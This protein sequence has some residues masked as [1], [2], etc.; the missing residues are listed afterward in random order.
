[1]REVRLFLSHKHLVAMIELLTDLI[2]VF[3]CLREEEDLRRGERWE[4]S[5]SVERPAHTGH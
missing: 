3:L 4:N 2:S 1:M 5:W